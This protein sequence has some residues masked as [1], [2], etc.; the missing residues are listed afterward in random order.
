MDLFM[1]FKE[2]YEEWGKG[3]DHYI[4]GRWPQAKAVFDKT[5]VMLKDK[6]IIDGPSNTLLEVI[7]ESGG[8]APSDWKG[9]RALTE[10]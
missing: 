6:G 10:K 3:F 7:Q 1:K 9:Y 4:G 5:L 8:K 2:F